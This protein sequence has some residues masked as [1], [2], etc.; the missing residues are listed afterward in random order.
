M[1]MNYFW[2]SS[3]GFSALVFASLPD[4]ENPEACLS[5]LLNRQFSKPVIFPPNPS[6]TW[7]MALHEMSWCPKSSLCWNTNIVRLLRPLQLPP[8]SLQLPPV[9]PSHPSFWTWIEHHVPGHEFWFLIH[10]GTRVSTQRGT[11]RPVGNGWW[12]WL[13]Q[14]NSSFILFLWIHSRHSSFL[15]ALQSTWMS[16]HVIWANFCLHGWLWSYTQHDGYSHCIASPPSFY[17]I[18]SFLILAAQSL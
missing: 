18:S 14:T 5:V 15:N 16:E 4:P 9:S 11:F 6:L 13:Q 12:K 10:W 17:F 3:P 8:L 2:K 7:N 1:D